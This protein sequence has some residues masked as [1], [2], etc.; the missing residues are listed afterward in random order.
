MTADTFT[1]PKCGSRMVSATVRTW[2]N[3]QGG[4]IFGFDM[5]DLSNVVVLDR[6]L[7]TICHHSWRVAGAEASDG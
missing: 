5:D 1:C 6:R 3:F 7:C 4:E 2:A